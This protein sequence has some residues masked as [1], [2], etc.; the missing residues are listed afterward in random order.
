MFKLFRFL[1]PYWWQVVILILATG[2][3]V[4]TTLRLP[5]LMADIINNGIVEG[6]TD[7]IWQTGFRMIGLAIV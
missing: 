7:Y 2:L 5:A 1:K 3:Q 6:N 4:Y